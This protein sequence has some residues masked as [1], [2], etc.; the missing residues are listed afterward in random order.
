MGGKGSDINLLHGEAA[1]CVGGHLGV[2]LPFPQQDKE[3]EQHICRS[4][5]PMQAGVSWDGDCWGE[6]RK[7]EMVRA[8]GMQWGGR[9]HRG[10]G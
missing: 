4:L 8:G 3:G 2:C 6:E 5:K 1:L 9:V 10:W 7:G